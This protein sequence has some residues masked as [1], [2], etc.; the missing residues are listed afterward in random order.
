MKIINAK[1]ILLEIGKKTG[2]KEAGFFVDMLKL[3]DKAGEPGE[4]LIREVELSFVEKCSNIR[5][6][7]LDFPRVDSGSE[8]MDKFLVR[9]EKAIKK[10]FHAVEKK[11]YGRYDPVF[12]KKIF[13][14][15]RCS[16]RWPL[17]VGL[18]QEKKGLAPVLK[19]YLSVNGGRFP[20]SDFAELFKLNHAKLNKFFHKK[21]F[22][23][24]AVDF[25]PDK[26]VGFKFYPLKKMNC[27]YLCRIDR[28]SEISSMKN[29]RRF[30]P[31]ILFS[32]LP[33]REQ[34]I[35]PENIRKLLLKSKILVRYSCSENRKKS[36]Y[37]R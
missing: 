31:S 11:F 1:K 30:S 35:I 23:T 7:H 14:F 15:N 32:D 33:L 18:A 29:W 9:R 13:K 17:Q 8:K 6:L 19:V 36:I 16:G 27:G 2:N 12:L 34:L 26:S 28:R 25:F 10:L 24:V 21:K 4:S 22:D 37:V 5:I 20:L 3:L